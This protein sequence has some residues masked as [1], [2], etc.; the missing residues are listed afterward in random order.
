MLDDFLCGIQC[1]DFERI[2]LEIIENENLTNSE[3]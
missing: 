1:E 3:N 2:Y